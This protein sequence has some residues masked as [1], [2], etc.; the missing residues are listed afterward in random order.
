MYWASYRLLCVSVFFG[1]RIEAVVSYPIVNNTD[2]V[3]GKKAR[4][5][6]AEWIEEKQ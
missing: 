3:C 6:I 1:R 5:G 2:S 4:A